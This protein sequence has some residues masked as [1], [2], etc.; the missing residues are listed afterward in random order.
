MKKIKVTKNGPYFV[1]GKVPLKRENSVTNGE[2]IPEKWEGN[3]DIVAEESYALCRCGKSKNKPFCDGIHAAIGFKCNDSASNRKFEDQAQ[4]FDGPELVLKDAEDLCAV[5]RFCELGGN[6]WNLVQNSDDPE[7]KKLAVQESSNC[8]SGRL[9]V[10]DKKTGK[11]IEP[12]L[13]K[14]I[15]VTEDLGAELSGPLWVKGGIPIESAD[16]K[17]YEVRN[18]VTLCRCGKSK[19]KPFCGGE[20]LNARFVDENNR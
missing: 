12:K 9:V 6:V 16:G 1:T 2:G 8:P 15:S 5:A 19:N 17:E 13:E 11:E 18:R 10:L 20:H 7:A 4:T 3:G 14:S